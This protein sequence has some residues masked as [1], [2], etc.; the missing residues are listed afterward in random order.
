MSKRI[1][2]LQSLSRKKFDRQINLFIE[3]G[4]KPIDG[5]YKIIEKNSEVTYSQLIKINNYRFHIKFYK[6]S[7]I[8]EVFK[9]NIVSVIKILW[10][11][12][13]LDDNNS[14]FNIENE[15]GLLINW[16]K[17]GQVI[18]KL[19][20]NNG[21]IVDGK[22]IIYNKIVSLKDSWKKRKF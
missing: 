3:I 16:Y 2:T 13:F 4:C 7:H 21:K 12:G 14:E 6:N 8:K 20:F 18:S 5:S 10:N 9:R 1:H 22:H 11:S 17:N 15:S 19:N